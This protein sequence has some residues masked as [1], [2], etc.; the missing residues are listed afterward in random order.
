ME[1]LLLF[2]TIFFSLIQNILSKQYSITAKEQNLFLYSAI[3]A[4]FAMIFFV[5]KAGFKLSFNAA[6]LPYSIAFAA[7]YGSALVGSVYAYKYGPLSVSSLI[8][9]TSLIVP[10][11]YGIIFLNDPIKVTTYAGIFLL[12]VAL[13]L[14]NI[15][16]EKMEFSFK[17]GFFIILSF[18]GNGICSTAQKM[19]QVKFDG[20][21]KSEFMIVALILVV[22][23]LLAMSFTVKGNKKQMLKSC[24]CFAPFQ[25]IS[26]G[27]VNY[28]V[29]VLSA[30]IP[31]SVLFPS[32]TACGMVITFII[33]LTIYHEKLSK[34]QLIGY[35]T[36]MASVI[37][38]NL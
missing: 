6:F 1:Y 11:L 10:T 33:S 20:A 38:L 14:I 16:K 23:F 32:I 37:L 34:Q 19:Q 36:G 21:Y 31:V 9:S 12:L 35:F 15:K 24:L 29:M 22:L 7:S 5:V 25:G 2:I 4:F 28:F 18:I 30:L 17:W 26:N 8:L 3:S 27:I 13:T